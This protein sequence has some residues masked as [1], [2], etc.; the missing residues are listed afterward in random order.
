MPRHFH[1]AIIRH[2][3]LFFFVLLADAFDIRFRP[4]PPHTPEFYAGF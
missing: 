3:P 4:T 2:A 1:Y